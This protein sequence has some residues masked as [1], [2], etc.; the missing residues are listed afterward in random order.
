LFSQQILCGGG[1][2]EI[3]YVADFASKLFS[4]LTLGSDLIIDRTRFSRRLIAIQAC[5]QKWASAGQRRQLR[6]R[7]A[8]FP[9]SRHKRSNTA[10][11]SLQPG[12]ARMAERMI[13]L[14]DAAR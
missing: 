6:L 10:H 11:G 13:G 14:V 4:S 7:A 2:P 8:A 12:R 9:Q 3:C 1:I 5:I